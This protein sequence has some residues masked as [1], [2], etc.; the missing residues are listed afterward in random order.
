MPPPTAPLLTPAYSI[1]IPGF[2][3]PIHL[4]AYYVSR[5]QIKSLHPVLPLPHEVLTQISGYLLL[6]ALKQK[7]ND[8]WPTFR[9]YQHKAGVAQS[10]LEH[11]DDADLNLR[12]YTR[13]KHAK[14][15]G[16]GIFSVHTGTKILPPLVKQECGQG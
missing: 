3:L 8:M 9:T 14:S 5:P 7:E 1:Q 2:D 12:Q 6:D 10:D 16:Y 11:L 13:K 15:D 4:S